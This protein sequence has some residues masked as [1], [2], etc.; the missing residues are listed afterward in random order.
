MP[1]IKSGTPASL[2]LRKLIATILVLLIAGGVMSNLPA[3]VANPN[4][5]GPPVVRI[6]TVLATPAPTA[7]SVAVRFETDGPTH[8]LP[9]QAPYVPVTGDQVNVLWYAASG[10]TMAGIVLG[11]RAG[12][13]GNLVPNGDFRSVD[14]LR[15]ASNAIPPHMWSKYTAAG[16]AAV[17]SGV[18]NTQKQRQMLML[19]AASSAS[20]DNYVFSAAIPVKPGQLLEIDS[21]FDA[22]LGTNTSLTV[23][24]RVGWFASATDV[25]PNFISESLIDSDVMTVNADFWQSGDITVPLSAAFARVAVRANYTN[26]GAGATY[27]LFVGQVSARFA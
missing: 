1:P 13:S 17:V 24:T 6:G 20:S 23:Q 25:Y 9:Y 8:F 14:H 4:T 22:F 27:Q 2:P 3:A 21:M 7:T 12:Q 10:V 18:L 15:P 19:D 16:P 26:S 11:G 5:A